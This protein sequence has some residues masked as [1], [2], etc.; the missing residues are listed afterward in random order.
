MYLH[1]LGLW[2]CPT[3]PSSCRLSQ[4][5]VIH[6]TALRS[7]TSLQTERL[8]Q[9]NIGAKPWKWEEF[10]WCLYWWFVNHR[11]SEWF[12]CAALSVSHR[13]LLQIS[14][15]SCLIIEGWLGIDVNRPVGLHQLRMQAD[16]RLWDVLTAT[17]SCEE[18]PRSQWTMQAY[19]LL[20]RVCSDARL[21]GHAMFLVKECAGICRNPIKWRVNVPCMI[22]WIAEIQVRYNYDWNILAYARMLTRLVIMEGC[23]ISHPFRRHENM[24]FFLAVWNCCLNVRVCPGIRER[25]QGRLV[26]WWNL[27]RNSVGLFPP[28]GR[29]SVPVYT[30]TS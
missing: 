8:M 2:S 18:S 14:I 26:Q 16:I 20:D 28:V 30:A 19:C 21:K 3:G 15:F 1:V 7:W 25:A 22:C 24:H 12:R 6:N 4:Y 23:S 13:S 11:T 17:G 27:A 29:G 5:S 9:C 10:W